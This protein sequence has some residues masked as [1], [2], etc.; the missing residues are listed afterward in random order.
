[1]AYVFR[2]SKVTVGLP[3]FSP[4][5]SATGMQGSD[6]LFNDGL[7][8][9]TCQNNGEVRRT[10]RVI[11]ALCS[12]SHPPDRL[13][14]QSSPSTS[15]ASP[16]LLRVQLISF[17]R[18]RLS[19]HPDWAHST[20]PTNQTRRCYNKHK[21]AWTRRSA[22]R[23]PTTA[24]SRNHATTPNQVVPSVTRIRSDVSLTHVRSAYADTPVTPSSFFSLLSSIAT[25]Q[26]MDTRI[27]HHPSTTTERMTGHMDETCRILFGLG[28]RRVDHRQV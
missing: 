11:P 10:G 6:G 1:M 16:P 19:S 14:L 13:D 23:S 9:N 4:T 26:G 24:S 7:D 20:S 15:H 27:Y 21:S 3:T 22:V 5:V 2:P 18:N 28:Q 12:Q 25:I 17:S 8:L